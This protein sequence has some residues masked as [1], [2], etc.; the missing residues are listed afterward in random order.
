MSS[1]A[2]APV[3]PEIRKERDFIEATSRLSSFRVLNSS[4]DVLTPLE[5]RLTTDRLSL[6][7]RLLGSSESAYRHP[8]V[9][10]DLVAKLGYRGDQL[11]EARVFSMLADAA[12]NAGDTAKAAEVC[13][14]MIKVV[15]TIR[16]GRDAE[17]SAKAAEIAWRTCYQFGKTSSEDS[18]ENGRM[19]TRTTSQ[20]AREDDKRKAQM[21]GHALLL[22]PKEKISEVLAVWQENDS[23][24]P[25]HG[26]RSLPSSPTRRSEKA[27]AAP[28]Q[29]NASPM[30]SQ[31]PSFVHNLHL[32][33]VSLSGSRPGTPSSG[34]LPNIHLHQA[35]SAA[36]AA[37]SAGRAAANAYLPFR[38][39]TPDRSASP[40]SA[41]VGSNGSRDVSRE[42]PLS[43]EGL[44]PGRERDIRDALGGVAQERVREKLS[45]GFGAGVSW[46]IG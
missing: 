4:G 32:P 3:T 8:E 26:T 2:V 12:L 42:R 15:E 41:S 28:T 39:G 34:G 9:V 7:S 43:G 27:K 40:L 23:R 29:R 19:H 6:I 5:I 33:S 14:R 31:L 16:R 10:L 24:L 17:K 30:S 37:F 20:Q 45:K 46:L 36:R 1:L 22:C 44:A 13:N 21:L 38:T 11:A 35:E 25:T 18:D